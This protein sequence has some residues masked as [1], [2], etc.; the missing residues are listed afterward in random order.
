M[1]DRIPRDEE[2][3]FRIRD[4]AIVDAHGP[5]EQAIGWYYY[6]DDQLGFPFTASCIAERSLSPLQIDERVPVV[7]M[8]DTDDCRVEMFVL[9][10]WQDRTFGV[11]L[12]QLLP[13]DGDAD[14]DEAVADWHYWCARGYQLV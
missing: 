14:T 3:E 2:R 10:R 13:V 7:G 12:A 5:E 8:A 1:T 11:P 6:L 9:I 4:E